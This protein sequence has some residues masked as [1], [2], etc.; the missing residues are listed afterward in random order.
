MPGNQSELKSLRATKYTSSLRRSGG[1]DRLRGSSYRA[2]LRLL[3]LLDR[4]RGREH[5]FLPP[6]RYRRFIGNGD[7]L[8]VGREITAYMRDELGMGPS[9]DVLDAGCGAGRVAIPLTDM[10]TEGSYLGFDIVPHAIEWCSSTIGARHPNFRFEHVDIRQ[11]I[12][13]PEGRL[14]AS[15]FRFPAEDSSFDIAAL[16]GLISHLMP[17]EMDNY[18]AE[19]ARVLRA[20]GRCFATAYLVD[21]KVAENISRGNTAFS[22]THDHGNYFVHSK[23]EPTYAIAY[24]LEHIQAVAARYDLRMCQEPRLGTWG[25]STHRPASM[26][27]L[28]L[29]RA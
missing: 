20:G 26:D 23:E 12:Y 21:D 7:F 14:S 8:K 13:N 3:D 4:V 16:V 1:I 15:D 5:R 6:R 22:F 9:H 2:G 29:E 24:R 11:E 18:L 19:S 17:E 28:V 27:L 10:L 25:V